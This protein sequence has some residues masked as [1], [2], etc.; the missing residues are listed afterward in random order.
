ML[1]VAKRKT[2]DFDNARWVEGDMADFALEERFGLAIIPF[3]SFLLLLTVAEQKSCLAC[4]RDHLVNGG[5]LALNI[6]NPNFAVMAAWNTD[7][8][9]LWQPDDQSASHERWATRTY[10]TA[11]Q[12]LN[13]KRLEIDI[14]DDGAIISRVERNLRLRY[15]FRYEMEH[16]LE[17]SGFEIEALYGWFDRRPFDDDSSEMVWV[18][19]KQ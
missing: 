1:E 5:R 3:R 10:Q 14:S 7:K 19:R 15:V 8:R 18:A 13:E 12:Q 16:L 11:D 17:L 9:G 4:I 6:F 2:A